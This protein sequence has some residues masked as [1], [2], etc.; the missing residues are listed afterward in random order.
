MR[1][2]DKGTCGMQ[3]DNDVRAQRSFQGLVYRRGGEIQ[4]A[5]R[6]YKVLVNNCCS[7]RAP[8]D[9]FISALIIKPRY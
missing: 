7:L 5:A 6:S 2:E 4:V 1:R 9:P 3:L 8:E